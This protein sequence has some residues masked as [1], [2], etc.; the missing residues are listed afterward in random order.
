MGLVIGAGRRA[1]RVKE[2]CRIY[3]RARRRN[4]R[5]ANRSGT[6]LRHLF[7]IYWNAAAALIWPYEWV[8]VLL[9]TLIGAGLYL[10]TLV[11]DTKST[12]NPLRPQSCPA[13]V[14]QVLSSAQ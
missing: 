10:R 4:P 3:L 2:R 13:K 14:K 11:S 7:P 5:T 6:F 1:G 12:R 8:I 9:W